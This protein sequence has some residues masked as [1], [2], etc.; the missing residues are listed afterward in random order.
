VTDSLSSNSNDHEAS[1]SLTASTDILP[2]RTR[3]QT[4]WQRKKPTTKPDHLLGEWRATAIA[5]NDIS[6]SCLYTAGI[7]AQ[8]GMSTTLV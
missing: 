3:F 6:S 8:R 2:L 5:G 4:F 7:C 1:S